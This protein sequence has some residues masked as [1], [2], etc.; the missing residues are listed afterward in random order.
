MALT[1]VADDL[2]RALVTNL[3]EGARVMTHLLESP[4]L[5]DGFVDVITRS[6]SSMD[7][8][9]DFIRNSGIE[10]A[11]QYADNL[12]SG[13]R[14][15]LGSLGDDVAERFADMGRVM[16]EGGDIDAAAL[17]NFGESAPELLP[18]LTRIADT[19]GDVG[20]TSA[21]ILATGADDVAETG[22]DAAQSIGRTYTSGDRLSVRLLRGGAIAGGTVTAASAAAAVIEVHTG[23]ALSQMTFEAL[24]DAAEYAREHDLPFAEDLAQTAFE[25]TAQIYE[26]ANAGR[27]SIHNGVVMEAL[28]GDPESASA[29]DIASA[30]ARS[31]GWQLTNPAGL[32]VDAY[33]VSQRVRL[34][35][36]GMSAEDRDVLVADALIDRLVENANVS[37]L[38]SID[39]EITREDVE[40]YMRDHASEI[41]AL[42]ST[43]TRD[44]L[45]AAVPGLD[46]AVAS[47]EPV[48]PAG[49][50][51]RAITGESTDEDVSEMFRM[52]SLNLDGLNL[53]MGEQV[54]FGIH[55]TLANIL[56]VV[57]GI[58]SIF[59]QEAGANMMAMAANQQR[60]ALTST[61]VNERMAAL[62]RDQVVTQGGDE[63]RV[64]EAGPE[65]PAPD[66]AAAS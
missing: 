3:D 22:A 48:T 41:A 33:L 58:V 16:R 26:Y 59:N 32:A 7:D 62:P 8:V 35:N 63:F 44:A 20:Q 36:P 17:R 24:I 43:R 30:R 18:T 54:K 56:S 29:E 50:I 53:S 39:E 21:R 2:L 9:T 25:A 55:S 46:T 23:G 40:G 4:G 6:G 10:G 5:R 38:T 12:P 64:A 66:A 57:G 31:I 51:Y 49:S 52:A 1:A 27:T 19:W 61:E 65:A 45:V 15:L 14:S 11:A 42:P 28:G 34:E 47:A 37:A 60:L 13:M